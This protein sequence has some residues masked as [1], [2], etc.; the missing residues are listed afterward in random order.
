MCLPSVVESPSVKTFLCGLILIPLL[1][2]AQPVYRCESQGKVSYSDAPCVGAQVIDATPTQGM[3]RMSGKSSK[4]KEVRREEFRQLMDDALRPL[5]GKSNEEMRV[6]R[7][8]AMQAPQDRQRCF[9]L[10]RRLPELEAAAATGAEGP[11]KA[12]ADVEL[13]KARK[14]FFDLKC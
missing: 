6:L 8:R 9:A 7:K 12:Q 4:G 13:Y 3:D 11:R 14:Q 10:D 5:T 1:A 2:G